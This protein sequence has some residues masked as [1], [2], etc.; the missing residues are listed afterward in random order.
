MTAR[1]LFLTSIVTFD[2]GSLEMVTETRLVRLLS[3][4]CGSWTS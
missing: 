3:W 2:S 4:E 1:C